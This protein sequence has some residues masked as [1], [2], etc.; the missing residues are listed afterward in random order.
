MITILNKWI[1]IGSLH[2][3][4]GGNAIITDKKNIG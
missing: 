1:V 3:T 4:S 2:A